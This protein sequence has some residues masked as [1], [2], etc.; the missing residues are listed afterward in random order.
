[1]TV[2]NRP[3]WAASLA[4]SFVGRPADRSRRI[5]LGFLGT[6]AQPSKTTVKAQRYL[7]TVARDAAGADLLI[8]ASR[9]AG[10]GP[11]Q[12]AFRCEALRCLGAFEAS[13]LA[14]TTIKDELVAAFE[15]EPNFPTRL[16]AAKSLL[17][18]N[19]LP[20]DRSIQYEIYPLLAAQD[21][22][23]LSAVAPANGPHLLHAVVDY[24]AEYGRDLQHLLFPAHLLGELGPDQYERAA[25]T[26]L[27]CELIS[28]FA[29]KM[30]ERSEDFPLL[31]RICW[32]AFT[33]LMKLDNEQKDL[34][35]IAINCEVE[36][37][38][39]HHRY[40]V[41][42]QESAIQFLIQH[43]P[44]VGELYALA[45]GKNGASVAE[46]KRLAQFLEVYTRL[47]TRQIGSRW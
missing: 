6:D 43:G 40:P 37:G 8:S 23:R 45:S 44:V 32:T 46:Q 29:D 41:A 39:L 15:Q 12:R 10:E 18:L 13:P 22:A 20:P 2:I 16:A 25:A 35:G 3:G 11:E 34:K 7:A 19:V 31:N 30:W 27:L 28:K 33:S 42:V 26:L 24:C 5:L 9:L 4:K 1:M 21:F 38:I 14:G 47:M 36:M 17:A